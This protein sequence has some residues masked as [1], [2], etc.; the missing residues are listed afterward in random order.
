MGFV[1]TTRLAVIQKQQRAK[2]GIRPPCKDRK[3]QAPRTV[4]SS[5]TCQP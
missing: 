5:G 2:V 1:K 3:V 4:F